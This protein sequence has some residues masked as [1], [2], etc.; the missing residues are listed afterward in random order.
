MIIPAFSVGRTQEILFALNQLEN[1]NRLPDLEYFVDSPLSIEATEVIKSYPQYFNNRIQKILLNDKDPFGFKGLKFI[2]T[3]EESKMLNYL[4]EPCVIISAS[5]MADAGR[6]KHHISNNIENSRNSILFSGYCEPH[7]L[8]GRLK[9][10]SER[11]G[12][13]WSAT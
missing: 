5:G 2:K 8:G 4:N 9:L 11:S 10:A 12:H 7:S 6:V 3:V 1:E 13:F